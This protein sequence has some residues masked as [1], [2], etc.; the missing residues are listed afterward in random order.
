NLTDKHK[1]VSK[2]GILRFVTEDNKSDFE[3]IVLEKEITVEHYGKTYRISINNSDNENKDPVIRTRKS[4]D[5]FT[6]FKRNITKS[7]RKV[8][9]EQKIPSEIRDSLLVIAKDSIILWCEGIGYSAQG[10][11]YNSIN[12]LKIKII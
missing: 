10:M 3:E 5:T 11:E 4:G 2:Q 7:L 8:L 12:E 6:Y 9:N 1:A